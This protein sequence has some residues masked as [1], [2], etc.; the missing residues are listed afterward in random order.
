MVGEKSAVTKANRSAVNIEALSCGFL[1]L[2]CIYEFTRGWLVAGRV[3]MDSMVAVSCL[4]VLDFICNR[5]YFPN[6]F[7]NKEPDRT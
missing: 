4:H 7:S 6:A 2:I 3:A 1:G 5:F